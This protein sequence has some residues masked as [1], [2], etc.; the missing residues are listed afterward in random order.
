[1][2]AIV[3]KGEAEIVLGDCKVYIVPM[4]YLNHL[5][6]LGNLTNFY[7]DNYGKVLYIRH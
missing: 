5:F 1:M 3:P 4:S 6:L 7:M 2:D